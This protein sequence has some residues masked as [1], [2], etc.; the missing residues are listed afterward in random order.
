VN[1]I[2]ND[3][4]GENVTVTGLITGSD[5]IAQLKGKDLGDAIV[6]PSV[7]LRDDK[8]LD[9]ISVSDVEKSLVFVLNEFPATEQA[10]LKLLRTS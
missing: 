8:F 7:M 4:F 5:I 3:Y 6:I 1:F 10:L 2:R 9:D